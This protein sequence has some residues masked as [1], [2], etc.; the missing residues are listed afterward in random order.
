MSKPL[1]ETRLTQ[2]LGIPTP[3]LAGGLQWLADADYVAAA[4]KAG[5]MGFIT[6]ASLPDDAALIAE[7]RKCRDLLE[8]RPFGVNIS[9][10]PK[11]ASNDRVSQIVDIV[12]AEK[13]AFVE[14]S[15]R[16][17]VEYL[18]RLQGAGIKVIHKVP[19]V[20]YAMSA[21]K[22][23]VDAVSIVGYEC[24]GHP[25]L[26]LMSTFVQSAMAARVLKIPYIVG[27]GVG[28][29]EQIVS[30][31]AMGADGVIIGTRFLVAEELNAHPDFKKKVVEA[32][33]GDTMLVLSS[34]R[35]TVRILANETARE[36][37]AIEARGEGSLETLIPLMS[38][39]IGKQAYLTGDTSHGAL[40]MGHALAFTNEVKPFAAIV[41]QL[42]QEAEGALARLK[43][44]TGG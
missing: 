17:P 28:T 23:G 4:V 26:E 13:V 18:P 33:E 30:A 2:M 25:G 41:A 11:I 31:L 9:M 34:I 7:I 3:I 20:R 38:G 1:F 44:I 27:G 29:G 39:K 6:A 5:T 40:S 12:V 10:L 19:A 22:A 36:V 21:E 15:G 43:R 32:R 35:N 37:A 16:S 14:T 42:M 8:G 24:G